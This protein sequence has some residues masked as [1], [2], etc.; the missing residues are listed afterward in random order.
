MRE[1]QRRITFNEVE[2]CLLEPDALWD[3][4]DLKKAVKTVDGR[5]L[6]IIYRSQNNETLVTTAYWSSKLGKHR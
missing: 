4:N 3:E 1:S 6:V 5:I 2:H